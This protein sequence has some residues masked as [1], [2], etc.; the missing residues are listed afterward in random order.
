MAALSSTVRPSS[1]RVLRGVVFGVAL[2]ALGALAIV[3]VGS[4]LRPSVED[5]SDVTVLYDSD[6]PV[7]QPFRAFDLDGWLV[8]Q[9]DGSVRAFSAAEARTACVIDFIGPGHP[10]YAGTAEEYRGEAGFFHDRCWG[11]K[12]TLDG[13]LTFG[14]RWRG[15][16]EFE[17]RRVSAERVS[18][19]ASR[20]RLGLCARGVRGHD[21]S[22]ASDQRYMPPRIARTGVFW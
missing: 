18:L 14:P 1:T 22:Y 6:G 8:R 10:Y 3:A 12:W 15:M 21:C 2:S 16:D 19:D 13:T 9:A 17:V 20:V 5:R 4:M 11:S 7:A